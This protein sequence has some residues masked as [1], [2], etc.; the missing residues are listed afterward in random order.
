MDSSRYILFNKM[1][2]GIIGRPRMSKKRV[3]KTVQMKNDSQYLP[4][5][6]KVI[7]INDNP[8][9]ECLELL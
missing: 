5:G 4:D 2:G 3:E 9:M 1:Y 8:S 7:E 6:W